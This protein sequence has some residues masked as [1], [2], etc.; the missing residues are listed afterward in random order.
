MSD[1]YMQT[2]LILFIIN[3]YRRKGDGRKRK[4]EGE[5]KE[6]E[7]MAKEDIREGRRE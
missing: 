4:G 2:I 7:G 5:G 3:K 1:C 6:R